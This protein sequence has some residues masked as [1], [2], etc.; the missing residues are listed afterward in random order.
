MPPSAPL[1][2]MEERVAR[3]QVL[4]AHADKRY[5][6]DYYRKLHMSWIYHDSALEGTVYELS[7]LTAAMDG[8]PPE[9]PVLIPAYDEIQQYKTAI[10]TIRELIE[11]QETNIT[12]DVIR[13][14]YAVLAPEE[15]EGKA[16]LKYRKDMPLHRLYYHDIATPDKIG[17]KLRQLVDWVNL[18][19]T[20]R[21]MHPVRLGA[22]FH[23]HFMQVYPFPK[24]S[25]K[26]ARL[27]MNLILLRNGYPPAI[28]HTTER[29]RYYEALKQSAN[30]LS[31]LVQDSLV[32][33]V[34]SGIRYF[35][36][37]G[38][39]IPVPKPP[40]RRAAHG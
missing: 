6:N 28:I 5:L 34:E 11:K 8:R 9:D 26:V 2:P 24:Q 35:E 31:Q 21:A 13:A 39:R 15:V 19:E 37:A 32:S 22:K 7:E 23:F 29:Q 16:P 18:P 30:V 25:G 14:V 38:V 17:P 4:L 3:L 20:K 27:L 40:R 33:S 1:G 36:A 10:D 12:M